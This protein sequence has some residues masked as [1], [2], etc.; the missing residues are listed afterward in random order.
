MVDVPL[1]DAEHCK[2]KWRGVHST[3]MGGTGCSG[4]K[5]EGKNLGAGYWREWAL[6]HRSDARGGTSVGKGP[7]VGNRQLM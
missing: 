7:E 6:E 1:G 3:A 5:G 4:S 2:V